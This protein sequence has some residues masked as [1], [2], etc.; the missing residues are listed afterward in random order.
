ML[1]SRPSLLLLLLLPLLLLCPAGGAADSLRPETEAAAEV[2]A[3]AAHDDAATVKEAA[4]ETATETSV[5]GRSLAAGARVPALPLDADSA[6]QYNYVLEGAAAGPGGDAA[7]VRKCCEPGFFFSTQSQQCEAAGGEDTGFEV[8]ARH[9]R[10]VDAGGQG[11]LRVVP[12]KLSPCPGTGGPPVISEVSLDSHLLLEGG[13][14]RS[15]VTGYDHDHDH[16]CLE[17]AAPDAD[18]LL[19]GG[20]VLV[21]AQCV[22]WPQKV[23]ARK[24]CPLDHYYDHALG[25]CRPSLANMSDAVTLVREFIHL[26]DGGGADVR[27]TTGKLLCNRGTPRLVVADQAFLDA[28]SNLCERLSDKCHDTASYC[29]EYMW[30]AGDTTMTA[31]ASVCPV[32]AFHKCCPGGHVL[33]DEGCAPGDVSARMRQLLEVLDPHYGFPTENGGEL[34]VQELITPDDD[35]VQWWISKSGYLSVDTRGDSHDTMRYCVDDY[36]GPANRSQT[37]AVLCHAELEELVHVHLSLHPSQAGSVG[38]CCPH[39]HYFSAAS[40]S[41]RPDELGLELLQHP[42]VIAA[43]VTKLTFTSFPECQAAGGYHH[44]YVGRGALDDDHALLTPDHLLEVVALESGCEFTRHAFPRHAYCLEYTVD[45][46]GVRRPGVLVCPGAWRGYNLHTEKFGLTGILLGVSCAALFATAASLIST[47]VRRGLV[48]VKKVNTLAGRILLSYVL[49]YLV[50]FLLLMVNMKVEVEE[51]NNECQVMAWLLI[52]FLLAGF[53]WNTSICLESLLLTLHVETSENLRYLYHSLWAWGAPAVIA[54]LALTLDHYRQ[55]LPC[56][57]VTPKVGL[58]RC[59]FSDPT[60]TLLYFFLPMLL[61]LVANMVLL[62]VS[63]YVRAEKL[64]RLEGGPARNNDREGG[65]E[66][67]GRTDPSKPP[68]APSPVPAPRAPAPKR[69]APTSG[70]RVHHTRNTWLESVKLVV[71]SGVTWLLEVASFVITKYMVNPSESWYDYLWYVPSSVNALRGVG[72]FVILV[73]TPE[74]RIQ[75]RRTLLGLAR[76]S[77]VHAFSKSRNGEASSTFG[78]HG[79]DMPSS[80]AISEMTVTTTPTLATPH[81]TPPHPPPV[82]PTPT[83]RRLLASWTLAGAPCPR[84]PRMAMDRNWTLRRPD[85]L[86]DGAGHR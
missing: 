15:D 55:S 39:G 83:W 43:N 45:G 34:C 7:G 13:H 68:S 2:E 52:F 20:G 70:L 10:Q 80:G 76:Q 23:L 41:C 69:Q 46:G 29:V 31:V 77:G 32:E 78:R 60:A 37:V 62:L 35:D 3:P 14:L 11:A 16:Y 51:G 12:G 74:R 67:Q 27:V 4:E 36:L 1:P 71:W 19:G 25:H 66:M 26:D 59:F 53:Q 48:T 9:L 33:T 18:L 64:R 24:C 61:T 50:G 40:G 38:K 42:Q 44:Y 65:T 17:M 21:A 84:S 75:I 82:R 57:V 73:L 8:A 22:P 49:S 6:Q 58:Y 5:A 72:I 81:P 54:S 47:R 28:S 56:S 86:E 30:A 79:S 85:P 63:R